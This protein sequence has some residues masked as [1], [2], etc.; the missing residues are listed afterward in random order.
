V[1]ELQAAAVKASSVHVAG[2]LI[3]NGQTTTLD[4]S[5]KGA[6]VAGYLGV[7]GARFYV[8]SLNGQ[9][10]V[11]LN[12]AFLNIENAPASLCAQVCGKYVALP[13]ASAQRI[14]GLLSMQQLDQQ[15]FLSRS[16]GLTAVSGCV[17]SPTTING[18]SVLQCRQGNDTLDVAAHG[19]PYLLYW[20]G[21]N[22]QHLKFDDWNSVVLPP[23]PSP[24][25]VVSASDLG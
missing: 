5:I 21:P 13:A 23:A 15:I 2:T 18:Q 7:S 19:R 10:Y 16:M 25:Q 14:T 8:L 1:P 3:N 17:F 6:S 11:K 22:G 12:Q 4:F 9:S 24:S 20:S